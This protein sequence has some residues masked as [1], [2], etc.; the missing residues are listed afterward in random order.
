VPRKTAGK[1]FLEPKKVRLKIFDHAREGVLVKIARLIGAAGSGK[2]TELLRIMEAALPKLG[3]DPLRLGFASFTRAAR[4]EAVGRASVAWG[5]DPSVLEGQGWF[6]TVHSTCKRCLGVGPGQLLG[7]TQKDIEWIS[8]ALG[9]KLST[10][11]DDEVGRQR[12]IGDPVVAA[13][14]NC[15]SLCR[16]SLMPLEDVVR[17]MRQVDDDVPDFAAIVRIIQHYETAKNIEDRLDF[18][19]LL[20]RFA[21]LRMSATE[22]VN[23]VQPEGELPPVE[24]WLFD[25]QQDASPLLDLVCKRL[26]S[27][28]S[29]RWCYVV[30]DP[31]Q[32]IYGFAGS[33]ADCFLGWPAE[34]ERTMP[35]SYRCPA[36][37]LELGEKCLRRMSRGYFDRKVAPADHE[38]RVLECD[39]V[40]LPISLA[41]SDEDWLFIARTNYHAKRLLAALQATHLPSRWVKSPD[42]LTKRAEGLKALYALE[43]DEVVTGSQWAAAIELLPAINKDKQAVLTR[44]VKTRW[45]KESLDDWDKIFASDLPE[46]GAEPPLVA[47]IRSGEW[48]GLVDKGKQWRQMAAKHGPEIAAEPKIRVGTIHSVKGA[49]ADN[50]VFLTTIGSRVEQGMENP[51]QA[52]EEHRIAYVACTRARRNLYVVNEGKHGRRVPRME[53]L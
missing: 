50:V 6:R 29:V 38:G 34:K 22:G 44:G 4:A 46:V 18:T 5:V 27:A 14:L 17:R 20:M 49:E 31:F 48:C 39:D 13:A 45:A 33:S 23:T 7:D 3:N 47:A 26:V 2:T 40:D 25:E 9:V 37:I 35:K 52:D 10:E 19:D 42:G 28:P 16:S 53:V 30:G 36:P 32:A 43:R 15:W 24:A 21:G 41:K 12:F 8:K 1:R 51:D 11:L